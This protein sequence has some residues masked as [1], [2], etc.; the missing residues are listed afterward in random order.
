MECVSTTAALDVLDEE[1]L[2]SDVSSVI[3][4]KSVKE[5]EKAADYKAEIKCILYENKYGELKRNF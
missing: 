4:E 3:L 2:V 5:L 1:N